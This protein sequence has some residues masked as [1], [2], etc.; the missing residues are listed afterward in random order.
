MSKFK[1]PRNNM[2]VDS[3]PQRK[4]KVKEDYELFLKHGGHEEIEE[5]FIIRQEKQIEAR[6]RG[7]LDNLA[8]KEHLKWNKKI[9]SKQIGKLIDFDNREKSKFVD[10]TGTINRRLVLQ[11]G[12]MMQTPNLFDQYVEYYQNHGKLMPL[13]NSKSQVT[14]STRPPPSARNLFS[15]KELGNLD[16]TFQP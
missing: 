6:Y 12:R 2:S 5:K 7:S 13:S 15:K 8:G 4:K 16:F 3:P 1:K 10:R 11:N 14:L 9:M